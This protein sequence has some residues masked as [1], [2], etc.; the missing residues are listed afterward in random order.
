MKRENTAFHTVRIGKGRL[1]VKVSLVPLLLRFDSPG[2]ACCEDNARGQSRV[3][4]AID[5]E[6]SNV[7]EK[8]FIAAQ[9]LV[10]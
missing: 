10:K 6:R 9:D 4:Q 3:S 8:H 1:R 5:I 2:Q 7:R